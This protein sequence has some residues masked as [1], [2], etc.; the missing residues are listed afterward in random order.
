MLY[1]RNKCLRVLKRGGHYVDHIIK[2][3]IEID[4]KASNLRE[5]KGKLKIDIQKEL[6]EKKERVKEQ[7]NDE[8]E[9]EGHIIIEKFKAEA[10]AEVEKIH[11]NTNISCTELENQ[12]QEIKD[13]FCEDMFVKM[14]E[15]E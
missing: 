1:N 2:K 7:I 6:M 15:L 4:S 3:I 13:T 9:K 8:V 5:L 12:Y 11:E 14:I 10:V